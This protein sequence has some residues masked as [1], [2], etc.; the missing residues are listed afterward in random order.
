MGLAA[1]GLS[2]AVQAEIPIDELARYPAMSGLSMSPDGDYV[3]GLM[4]PPGNYGDERGIAVWDLTD[5]GSAPTYTP[6]NDRTQFAGVEALRGG[7]VQVVTR[8]AWTGALA[9]CGEASSMTGSTKTFVTKVYL[10]DVEMDDF[11]EPFVRAG[12][13]ETVCDATTVGGGI[14][15]TLPFDEEM[16]IVRRRSRDAQY[17]EYAT[18]NLETGASRQI[19]R[20]N[21]TDAAGL[22]DLRNVRL[23]TKQRLDIEDGEY[24]FTT[25]IRNPENGNFERHEALTWTAGNRHK[26]S[27]VGHDEASGKYYV[28]TDQFSDMTQLYFY[29]PVTRVY[30]PE[31]LFAHPE[32]PVG[33]VVL[34]SRA[35]DYN[36]LLAVWYRGADR[37]TYYVDEEWFA[38]HEGLKA[39]FPGMKI[40]IVDYT[41]DKSRIL[42]TTSTSAKPVTY[43]LLED[44]S[45]PRLLGATRPWLDTDAMSEMELIYY[46]ARD[47]LSIP[48]LLALP[49]GWEEGDDPAP[50]IVLP[51]GGPWA[52][53]Y[54][55]AYSGGDRWVHFFTSRGYAVLK[56]QYRGSDDFG[57]NLWLAGD[58][59]WGQKM[60]DDKDDGARWL[61]EQGI[62]DPDRIAIKGFSYGGF[63]AMAATVRPDGPF[64][65][66][67]AGAGVSNL[68]RLG[69]LWGSN[70]IQRRFQGRTV[71]GMDPIENADMANIPIL[72][73]HGERDT[74]VE[75]YHSQD[76]YNAI[77]DRVPTRLVVVEDMPHGMPWPAH[78]Q[79]SF[80]A[81][82][83]FLRFECDL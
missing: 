7:K 51:H 47:G 10:T 12:A 76:F 46:D 30:D 22:W 68:E 8:Q 5:P 64:K 42:F 49:A 37:E 31:P 77:K 43:Y 25:L 19:Y 17:I 2:S 61:V 57:R 74:R 33:G 27:V 67:I 3:V 39:A 78:Y 48:A 52:R 40:G 18:F 75:L 71:D 38:I 62:A 20:E 60:Q 36:Q 41:D 73:Y 63:A 44:K 15:T 65:C 26:I 23:L 16:V 54:A 83:R 59:E 14:E 1:L 29:D 56:P 34:G 24:F 50:A 70:R 55:G 4:V 6:S 21:S 81:M 79:E 35:N 9:F 13:E 53:D 45:E 32:F 11:D 58:G 66:A 28:V 80:E 72:I 69:N 82:E